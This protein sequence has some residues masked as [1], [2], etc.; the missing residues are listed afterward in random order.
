MLPAIWFSHGERLIEA[1]LVRCRSLLQGQNQPSE[2]RWSAARPRL[3]RVGPY[4][5]GLLPTLAPFHDA[6]VRPPE[7]FV[8]EPAVGIGELTMLLRCVIGELA[9]HT[10]DGE[11]DAG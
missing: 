1:D 2:R 4:W 7:V 6:E 5:L 3:D 11:V 9:S 8:P 10:E